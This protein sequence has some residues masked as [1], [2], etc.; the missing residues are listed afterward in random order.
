MNREGESGLSVAWFASAFGDLLTK[1]GFLKADF[2][3]FD[4]R[5]KAA[6]LEPLFGFLNRGL[7]ATDINILGLL[8][9]LCHDRDLSRSDFGIAPENRHVVSLIADTISK[10]ADPKRG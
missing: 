5:R 8:R 9:D 7:S 3:F 4:F 10:L 2:G 1:T 6:G